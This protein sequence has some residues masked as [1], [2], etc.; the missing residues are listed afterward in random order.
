MKTLRT[1][2]QLLKNNDYFPLPLL[3][4]IVG[5]LGF[6][7]LFKYIRKTQIHDHTKS[8]VLSVYSILVLIAVLFCIRFWPPSKYEVALIESGGGGG[9]GMEVNFG[10]SDLG[11]GTDY[12]SK[13]LDVQN[14]KTNAA[15]TEEDDPIL[16]QDASDDENTAVV[17][18]NDNP[19]PAKPITKPNLTPAPQKPKVNQNSSDALSNIIKGKNKG[20]DGDDGVA[21]N[22]GK[23]NGNLSS[24]GYYNTGGSGGGK[25]GGKGKGD[26]TGIGDGTGSGT[27]G[28]NGNGNGKGSGSG[29]SLAGRSALSKPAPNYNCN[30][31]G[32]VVVEVTVDQNGNVIE[33]RPGA[34]GTTNAASCLTSQAKAAAMKTKWSASP[35]G[36]SKQVGTITYV[37][38]LKD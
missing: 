11:Q 26:G 9:G 18:K 3:V 38:S 30:E 4:I 15:S 16:A 27:G 22:K 33:A 32:K 28:G 2:F 24:D 21:G 23:S 36:A 6:V 8:R 14:S 35:T 37:F 31:E 5:V 19:K 29:Y 25:G 20:G 13:V 10:D 1:L 7:V 34:R 12:Q 17:P